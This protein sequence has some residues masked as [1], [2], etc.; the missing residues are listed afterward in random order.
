MGVPNLTMIQIQAHMMIY[1][2]QMEVIATVD[3]KFHLTSIIPSGRVTIQVSATVAIPTSSPKEKLSS[4]SVL[5]NSGVHGSQSSRDAAVRYKIANALKSKRKADHLKKGRRDCGR[6]HQST[7]PIFGQGR[8]YPH[9]A[10]EA[11]LFGGLRL[12]SCYCP[13]ARSRAIFSS[14][15]SKHRAPLDAD[16]TVEDPQGI[17]LSM[18]KCPSVHYY[19]LTYS[20]QKLLGKI[21]LLCIF[22]LL[23]SLGRAC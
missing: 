9:W 19:L 8:S 7:S 6:N 20:L 21:S 1:P 15:I 16:R 13:S 10:R 3:T 11:P 14:T 12:H 18:T 4:R 23:S 5:S 22:R 2:L 17:L